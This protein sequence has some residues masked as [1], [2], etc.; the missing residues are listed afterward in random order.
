MT[1]KNNMAKARTEFNRSRLSG[2]HRKQVWD[3]LR[4][5]GLISERKHSPLTVEPHELNLFFTAASRGS[6]TQLTESVLPLVVVVND[7]LNPIFVFQPFTAEIV[8]K[9]GVR[10][11]P[12]ELYAV[13]LYG[14][15]CTASTVR[16][17]LYKIYLYPVLAVPGTR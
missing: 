9:G 6:T 5:L 17:H 3:E 11:G 13:D 15:I 2:L 14:V 4:N 12:G 8:N 1:F 16:G 10:F 7:N